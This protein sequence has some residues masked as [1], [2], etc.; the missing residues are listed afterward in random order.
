[1]SP[2]KIPRWVREL[3]LKRP[4]FVRQES[5]RYVRVKPNW[6]RP[7]GKDS[8]MRLQVKGWPP[9]V[10]I[11]YRTP[12]DY[13]NLHPSGYKEVLVYR[14][15]D[16]QGLNP[17]IHA[18]RIASSVGMRKK[19]LIVEEA[20]KLGLKIL[21]P[22]RLMEEVEEVEVVRPEVEGSSQ[23]VEEVGS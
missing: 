6:R 15:E 5:W 2:M 13:R 9:L 23:E 11:G 19:L 16:L 7:R 22:P 17:E 20:R 12:K 1:M 8:K 3:K 18:I 14:P 10:K 4:E 21:N